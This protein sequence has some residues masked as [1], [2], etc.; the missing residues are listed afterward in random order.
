MGVSAPAIEEIETSVKTPVLPTGA[1]VPKQGGWLLPAQPGNKLGIGNRGGGRPPD[2]LKALAREHTDAAV[3]TLIK[4]SQSEDVPPAARVS[5]SIAI[6]DRGY[7]KPVQPIDVT[8]ER[9]V[10]DLM[11]L[12]AEAPPVVL[13]WLMRAGIMEE[14]VVAGVLGEVIEGD[15][16]EIDSLPATLEASPETES[17]L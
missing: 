1:I 3:N 5:A 15:A 14:P 12:L 10:A 11:V 13:E 4:V 17:S 8:D 9:K 7:G 2:Y 16:R 6:L